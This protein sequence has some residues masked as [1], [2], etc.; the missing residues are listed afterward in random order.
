M[1][2]TPWGLVIE[3]LI[4]VFKTTKNTFIKVLGNRGGNS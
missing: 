4:A 3:P 2:S 1:E